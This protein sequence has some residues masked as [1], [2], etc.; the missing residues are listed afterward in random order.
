MKKCF[1]MVAF[2]LFLIG[3]AITPV[4]RGMFNDH[5]YYS[6]HDPNIQIKIDPKFDYQYID[7]S[8]QMNHQFYYKD[9][10]VFIDCMINRSSNNNSACY[11]PIEKIYDFN[12]LINSG[13]ITLGE[14]KWHYWDYVCTDKSTKLLCIIRNLSRYASNHNIFTIRYGKEI[15]SEW[16]QWLNNKIL[17][18]DQTNFYHQFVNG[19]SEDIEISSYDVRKEKE[20]NNTIDVDTQIQG[21]AFNVLPTYCYEDD[22]FNIQKKAAIRLFNNNIPNGQ[23]KTA[24][25]TTTIENGQEEFEKFIKEITV[26]GDTVTIDSGDDIV[27]QYNQKKQIIT[28]IIDKTGTL[29]EKHIKMIRNKFKKSLGLF[30]SAYASSGDIISHTM[31][32]NFGEFD[33]KMDFDIFV[34]GITA[35]EG[36]KYAVLEVRGS[37]NT[38]ISEREATVACEGYM[39]RDGSINSMPK[40]V[41]N[42]TVKTKRGNEFLSL[43]IISTEKEI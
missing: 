40:S 1:I 27:L 17:T 41:M 30:F 5:V 32:I 6:T 18:N 14:K 43:K 29:S 8:S 19:F 22:C 31:Q 34:H 28:K 10:F 36:N 23:Y 13:D 3:C 21:E 37:G 38:Q 4:K 2:G 16:D 33:L 24:I 15:C 9:K 25:K 26:S 7:K 39:I 11:L 20:I 42:L 35:F 12:N